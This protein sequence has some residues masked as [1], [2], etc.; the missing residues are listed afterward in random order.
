MKYQ[1]R[2]SCLEQKGCLVVVVEGG[3]EV[4]FLSCQASGLY[5]HWIQSSQVLLSPP[6]PFG[7]STGA[8]SPPIDRQDL[9]GNKETTGEYFAMI[10]DFVKK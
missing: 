4:V 2:S 7:E 9:L 6:S 10:D 5:R 1:W 3:R 8:T